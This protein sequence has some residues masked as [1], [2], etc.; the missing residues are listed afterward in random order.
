M[1][2]FQNNKFSVCYQSSEIKGFM[3]FEYKNILL[4]YGFSYFKT[5]EYLEAFC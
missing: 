3:L 2:T 4:A 5:L 1:P